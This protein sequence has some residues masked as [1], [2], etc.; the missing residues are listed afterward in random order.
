MSIEDLITRSPVTVTKGARLSEAA[1]RMAEG[2]VGSVVVVV[3]QKEPIGVLTDRDIA[4]H[5]AA[6]VE[7]ARVEEVMTAHPVCVRRGTDVEQ[8]I[9][10]MEAHEVRRILVLDEDGDLAGVVSLDDIVMHLSNT[11]GKLAGLIR[12]EVARV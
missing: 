7:D 9:E 10:R 6:G 4:L 2:D 12:A 5:M 11:L 8:C 1:R 3:D